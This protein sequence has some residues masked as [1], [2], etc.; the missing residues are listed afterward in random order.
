M[1]FTFKTALI[2]NSDDSAEQF[3]SELV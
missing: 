1:S 2:L 3:S